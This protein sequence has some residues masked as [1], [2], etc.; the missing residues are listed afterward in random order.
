MSDDQ[1][2]RLARERADADRAYNEAFTALD[3]ALF[4]IARSEPSSIPLPAGPGDLPAGWR[5][6]V[7]RAMRDWLGPWIDAQQTFTAQAA[8]AIRALEARD[9]DRLDAFERFQHALVVFLQQITA[10]VETKERQLAADVAAR[11][12]PMPDLQAQIAV[13]QRATQMLTRTLGAATTTPVADVPSPA[14]TTT[15]SGADDYKY[16]AFEDQFR[17]SIDEIRAKVTAYVPL[18]AGATNVLDV[19]CGR[20]EFLMALRNAG[21]TARGVDVNSEMVAEARERGL[22]AELADALSYVMAAPDESIGGLF[23]A[24]VVEHLQPSYLLRLLDAAFQKLRPGAPIVLET[25]NPT[26]WVAFFSSYLRDPTH[27]RPLH[28]DTLEYLVRASGF[29]NVSVRY[30]APVSEAVRMRS[31]DLPADLLASDDAAVR[32]LVETAHA[33]NA[34]AAILN[35]LAFSN[36]DY[37]IVGYRS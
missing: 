17:G 6:P 31:I 3:A 22:D 12:A 18:F 20:G 35:S 9:R 36:Q 23:A 5:G 26:C 24:Q 16:L 32:A 33:V 29:T 37:A 10:F 30:G 34:N 13:L 28:P 21:V 19:G 8:A 4:K 2:S 27:V 7:L 1:H 15:A 11:F 14:V 25:I